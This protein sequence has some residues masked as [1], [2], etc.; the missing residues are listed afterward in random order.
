MT[1]HWGVHDPATVQGD[2]E[3]KRK[4]FLKA[5]T[6][7]YQRISLFTCLPIETLSSI[8]L[9]QKLDEIGRT[10]MTLAEQ[11]NPRRSRTI[12]EERLTKKLS[13]LDRSVTL[14]IFLGMF[15]GRG[16]GISFPGCGWLLESV[17]ILGRPTSPLPSG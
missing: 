4:A 6:E 9:K 14:W 7:L 2:D 8:A 5:Y 11:P 13:F 10:K 3:T 17:S 1:A 12:A 15:V 16:M